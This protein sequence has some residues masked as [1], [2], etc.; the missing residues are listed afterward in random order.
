[1][2]T[3]ALDTIGIDAEV[4]GEGQ[5]LK[6]PREVVANQENTPS[7][8]TLPNG[9]F[10]LNMFGFRFFWHGVWTTSHVGK[11]VPLQLT[12]PDA[13]CMVYVPTFATKT[14]QM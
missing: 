3:Q 8:I 5:V 10:F 13:Q 12:S 11:H 14:T 4:K 7:F 6:E 9:M 1:M 2:P